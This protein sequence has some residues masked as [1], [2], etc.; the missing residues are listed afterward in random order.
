MTPG[1]FAPNLQKEKWGRTSY[2]N[3]IDK[4]EIMPI[5]LAILIK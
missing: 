2:H 5:S 4:M 1:D 3:K